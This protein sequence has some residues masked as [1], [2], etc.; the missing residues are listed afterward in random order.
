VTTR[1]KP[2]YQ[3]L[4]R[5]RIRIDEQHYIYVEGAR[6][7]RYIPE[8]QA[9]QFLDKDRLREAARG[10]RLVEVSLLDLV[11]QLREVVDKSS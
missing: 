11:K 10:S 6:I 3:P 9:L 2:T 5:P 4:H 8:R 7:C 1:L